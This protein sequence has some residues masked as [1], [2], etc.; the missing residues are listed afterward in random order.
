LADGP[1]FSPKSV[2]REAVETAVRREV[3]AVLVSGDVI[4][5]GNSYFEAYGPFEDGV[6]QLDEA[7]IDTVVVSGNHDST[8]LPRLVS[9]LDCDGLYCLGAEG[10]WERC[11]IERDGKPLV[12]ID[13]WSFPHQ[14]Y[15]KSP[16]SAYEP[17]PIDDDTPLV[18][19]L[20][21]D[22]DAPDSEYA[23]VSRAEL[24]DTPADAWLLGHIHAPGIRIEGNPTVFYPGSPQPLDPGETGVHGVWLLQRD[25]AGS[26]TAEQLPIATVQYDEVEINVTGLEDTRDLP[27]KVTDR[28]QQYVESNLD[29]SAVRLLCARLRLV[30][31]T[32]THGVLV[33]QRESFESDLALQAGGLDI[34]VDKLDIATRPE[35]DL[36]T[37]AG[38][39]TPV[40]YL[41]ELLLELNK[42]MP[43]SEAIKKSTGAGA[44]GDESY[45]PAVQ[46]DQLISDTTEIVRQVRSSGTYTPLRRAG[47]QAETNTDPPEEMASDALRQQARLLLNELLLQAEGE[48]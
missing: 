11:T 12:H 20:H 17:N 6:R 38:E 2:W 27:A 5:E 19:L 10:T 13:G 28:L 30:G 39:T 31:E 24:E 21:A 29:A 43:N 25:A 26:F 44:D 14:H 9:N 32:S 22:L 1:E 15:Y 7:G 8:L 40:G 35:V 36:H 37:L 3:D 23:P 45:S 42:D 34:H 4:D 46:H 48:P 33:R 41:A 16:V 47:R 18:G